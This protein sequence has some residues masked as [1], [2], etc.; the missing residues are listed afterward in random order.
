VLKSQNIA[1]TSCGDPAEE[2]P[3][4]V[5]VLGVSHRFAEWCEYDAMNQIGWAM[6]C[7]TKFVWNVRQ[8]MAGDDVDVLK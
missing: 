7:T 3:V 6:D 8:Q 4:Q 5:K 2:S 1:S